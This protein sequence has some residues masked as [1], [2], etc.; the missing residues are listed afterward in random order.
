MRLIEAIVEANH[1]ALAGDSQAGLHPSDF[2]DSLP[3][4]ALTCIDARLNRLLPEVLGV[5][6]DEFIWLRNAGNI[7][8]GPL[9]GSMRT[10]ALACAIKGGREV[11]V[12]GHTDCRV[13]QVSVNQ[14]IESFRALGIQRAHLPDNLVEFFGLFASER[15]NV[16]TGVTHIRQSPLISPKIPVHGLIVNSDSGHLEWLVNGY[17]QLGMAVPT[18]ASPLMQKIEQA[19]E[20]IGVLSDLKSGELKLPEIKIGDLTLDAQKLVSDMHT[21]KH[22]VQDA[23]SGDARK[24]LSEIQVVKET[25]QDALTHTVSHQ[26]PVT[27]RPPPPIAIPPPISHP[28]KPGSRK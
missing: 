28:K 1:R 23:L 5:P 9:S 21:V 3:L 24:W 2:K 8:L 10:L 20:A 7:V 16:I 18:A 12:I 6:E 13:R 25:V 27:A 22:A 14:L 19:K 15:Q 17:D 26:P 11:A 4:V